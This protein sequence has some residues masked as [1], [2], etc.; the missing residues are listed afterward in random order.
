MTNSLSLSQSFP[1]LH[2][3][4]FLSFL[5]GGAWAP[6]APLLI[7]PCDGTH[8]HTHTHT[9]SV[10]PSNTWSTD[11]NKIVTKKAFRYRW[12]TRSSEK[13]WRT[14]WN[15]LPRCFQARH[16]REGEQHTSRPFGRCRS[17][18]R[19]LLSWERYQNRER[20]LYIISYYTILTFVHTGWM[21]CQWEHLKRICDLL[22]TDFGKSYVMLIERVPTVPTKHGWRSTGA[23]VSETILLVVV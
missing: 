21:Q 14:E 7:Q 17:V 13:F 10:S 6:K 18:W 16:F 8:T 3:F 12:K 23:D 5:G 22:S 11:T 20:K 9:P 2:L 15:H 19:L 1:L 4:F